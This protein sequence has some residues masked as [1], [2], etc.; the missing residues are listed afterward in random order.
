MPTYA[1]FLIIKLVTTIANH[2]R[3][4]VHF[5]RITY[6]Y[7]GRAYRHGKRPKQ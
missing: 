2:S 1:I 4:T 3:L 5:P 7:R 6:Q